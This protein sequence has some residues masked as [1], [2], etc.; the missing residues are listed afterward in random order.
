MWGVNILMNI[1]REMVAP[2]FLY[3]STVKSEKRPANTGKKAGS[4]TSEILAFTS[5]IIRP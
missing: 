2:T 1:V 5:R 4:F 3:Q